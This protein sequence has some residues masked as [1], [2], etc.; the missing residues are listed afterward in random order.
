MN[1]TTEC[2]LMSLA[3]IV[4]AAVCAAFGG[5]DD[6]KV[7]VLPE[8]TPHGVHGTLKGEAP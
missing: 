2:L 3:L 8:G 7:R 6:G 1:N 5:C 4:A